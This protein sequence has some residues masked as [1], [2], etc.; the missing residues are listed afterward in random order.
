M[1]RRNLLTNPCWSAEDLGEAMPDSPHA[2]SVAL[3]RWKDVIAYEE[4]D[5]STINSLQAIYTRFGLNPIV[6]EGD[7]SDIRKE[8]FFSNSIISFFNL[9]Y[10]LS[11]IMGLLL[12]K[13][14]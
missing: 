11:E 8:N 2:V 6:F 7:A 5:T 9:S 12:L 14:N 3:P 4:K 10:S 1:S 13:Y